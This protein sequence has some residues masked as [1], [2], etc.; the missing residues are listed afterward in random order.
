MVFKGDFYDTMN[1]PD[2]FNTVTVAKNFE[3]LEQQAI[4]KVVALD[5]AYS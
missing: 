5:S 3:S 1:I 4:N 2:F